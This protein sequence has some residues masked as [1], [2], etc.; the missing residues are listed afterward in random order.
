MT[1]VCPSLVSVLVSAC[2]VFVLSC[3]LIPPAFADAS[4]CG[5]IT[6]HEFANCTSDSVCSCNA[7][8]TGNGS[9]CYACSFNTSKPYEG[10]TECL[11]C[12]AFSQHS[13]L[14]SISL[15]D[16][17]CSPGYFLVDGS[18]QSCPLGHYKSTAGS[19]DCT[20]CENGTTQSTGSDSSDLCICDAGYSYLCPDCLVDVCGTDNGGCGDNVRCS[21]YEKYHY[22][23]NIIE[24]QA[25]CWNAHCPSGYYSDGSDCVKIS[26]PTLVATVVPS[27]ASA[28][29]TLQITFH[30]LYIFQL[31]YQVLYDPSNLL[32][33]NG[34]TAMEFLNRKVD[35]GNSQITTVGPVSVTYVN[36][37]YQLVNFNVAFDAEATS[38]DSAILRLHVVKIDADVDAYVDIQLSKCTLYDCAS[39]KAL[40]GC[41]NGT[42]ACEDGE[43]CVRTDEAPYFR[44]ECTSPYISIDGSCIFDVCTA[45]HGGC[46][47]HSTCTM[48]LNGP[49]CG[50]CE[51]GFTGSGDTGCFPDH[52]ATST[53]DGFCTN[54]YFSAV[55]AENLPPVFTTNATWSAF[56][57]TADQASNRLMEVHA[58]FWDETS[59]VTFTHRVNCMP[60][61]DP[62]RILASQPG[63]TY[64]AS[65]DPSDA[66]HIVENLQASYYVLTLVIGVVLT[67]NMDGYATVRCDASDQRGLQSTDPVI[68]VISPE[69]GNYTCTLR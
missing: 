47:E 42:L 46:S 52:C 21:N 66:F 12:P 44:C 20:I 11:Q 60:L 8:Y 4:L 25:I 58:D 19:E 22:E 36:G 51:S 62:A 59:S 65:Y 31:Y 37:N 35:L 33:Y 1:T 26:Q 68:F 53:C 24:S 63:E 67:G 2:L 43:T 38:T 18:C 17:E 54:S 55:C 50:Y 9:F 32:D 5:S 28:E 57:F 34:V 27:A 56:T 39:S 16:C 40:G 45:Y 10:N 29:I 3:L 69:C 48:T 30:L 15:S 6:C 41:M 7:G 49:V 13:V 23:N 14:S 61:Y 64:A